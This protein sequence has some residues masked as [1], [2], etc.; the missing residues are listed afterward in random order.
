MATAS[1]D[2]NLKFWRVFEGAKKSSK[3]KSSGTAK[4]VEEGDGIQKKGRTGIN[5]R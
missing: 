4:D 5:V 2:E 1:S 3:G